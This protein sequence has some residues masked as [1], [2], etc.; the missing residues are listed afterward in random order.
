M[1]TRV[2]LAVTAVSVLFTLS[3]GV[4]AFR[5]RLRAQPRFT[6]SEA[7]P[8]GPRL[9]TRRSCPALVENGMGVGREFERGRGVR[10]DPSDNARRVVDQCRDPLFPWKRWR[11]SSVRVVMGPGGVLYGMTDR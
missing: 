11:A 2:K 8:T 5:N 9:T 7:A 3:G 4:I 10:A 1:K 6:A